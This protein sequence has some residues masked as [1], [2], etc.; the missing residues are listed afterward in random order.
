MPQVVVSK[1]AVLEKRNKCCDSSK[2][3]IKVVQLFIF[4]LLTYSYRKATK[5]LKTSKF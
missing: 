2:I 3:E 5:H 1:D 4:L